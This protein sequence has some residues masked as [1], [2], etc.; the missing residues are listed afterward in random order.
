DGFT[1]RRDA[2]VALVAVMGRI[3]CGRYQGFDSICRRRL[4]GAANAEVDYRQLRAVERSH[5]GQLSAEVVF[6]DV[7]YSVC[8]PD[9]V[10]Q[11]FA[12]FTYTLFSLS[13]THP[14]W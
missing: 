1:E 13:C 12:G 8:G 2:L 11:S 10:V 9:H 4:V 7:R 6:F 14:V 5:F 3:P